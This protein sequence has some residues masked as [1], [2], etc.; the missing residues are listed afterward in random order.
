M[1]SC[2]RGNTRIFVCLKLSAL[3]VVVL[4]FTLQFIPL[5]DRQAF[6][7]KIW[8]GLLPGGMLILSEKL[9]FDD[10]R[11]EALQTDMHHAFK[12][13]QGYSTLEISQKRT[14]LR[15][16]IRCRKRSP[17]INSVCRPSALAAWKFG[18]S[19]LIFSISSP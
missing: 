7:Q 3:P 17:S 2:G 9:K 16:C 15:K 6:L 14:T 12:K 19:I 10:P 18:S 11:Q 13:A 8:Q 5:A 1:L 4:N